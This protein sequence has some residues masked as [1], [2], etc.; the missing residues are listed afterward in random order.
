[1]GK[2]VANGAEFASLNAA[3]HQREA[4]DL[5]GEQATKVQDDGL[6]GINLMIAVATGYAQTSTLPSGDFVIEPCAASGNDVDAAHGI[7]VRSRAKTC[8]GRSSKIPSYRVS[9]RRRCHHARNDENDQWPNFHRFLV[10]PSITYGVQLRTLTP[11]YPPH[12][13]LLVSS[14]PSQKQ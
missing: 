2:R 14:W 3:Q 7:G 12:I 9:R 10:L 4:G 13:F 1:M 6:V 8:I 11:L 5:L